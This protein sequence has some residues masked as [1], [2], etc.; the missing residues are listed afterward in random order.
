MDYINMFIFKRCLKSSLNIKFL[1]IIAQWLEHV[2]D[3]RKVV[4]SKLTNS[5]LCWDIA[6]NGKALVFDTNI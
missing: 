5:I 3:K 6:K 1:R 4:S 2:P